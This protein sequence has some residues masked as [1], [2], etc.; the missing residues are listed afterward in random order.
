MSERR[1]SW[2]RTAGA[3]A[4]GPDVDG[5]DELAVVVGTDGPV[6][7]DAVEVVALVVDVATLRRTC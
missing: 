4:A 6:G 2:D 1:A 5:V 3:Y 7:D